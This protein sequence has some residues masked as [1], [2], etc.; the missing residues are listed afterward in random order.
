MVPRPLQG[1]CGMG[2]ELEV[3]VSNRITFDCHKYVQSRARVNKHTL[4]TELSRDHPTTL[5]CLGLRLLEN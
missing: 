4:V 1:V 3:V 5:E 2:A